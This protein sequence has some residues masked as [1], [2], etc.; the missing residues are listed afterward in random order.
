ML[1]VLVCYVNFFGRNSFFLKLL[2]QLLRG[3]YLRPSEILLRFVGYLFGCEI[4][5]SDTDNLGLDAEQYIFCYQNHLGGFF[6][7]PACY[8]GR[9]VP[10]PAAFRQSFAYLQNPVVGFFIGK[11]PGQLHIDK[12][13][14]NPEHPAAGKPDPF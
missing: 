12:I 3:K 5:C 6:R 1:S 9:P 14:L 13:F 2:K 7:L 11:I 10:V 4:L 8:M